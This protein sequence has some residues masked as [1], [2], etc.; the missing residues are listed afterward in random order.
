MLRVLIALLLGTAAEAQPVTATLEPSQYVEVRAA[1]SGRLSQLTGEEGARVATGDVLAAIDASVQAARVRLAEAAA[2]ATGST[3][4]GE[5]ALAMAETARDRIVEARERGVAQDWEVE[6]SEQT[7]ALAEADLQMVR[8]ELELNLGQL[9]MER[10]MLEEFRVRAPFDGTVLQVFRENGEIVDTQSV[11][12]Q[13]GNLA[14]LKAT[15]FVPVD[16]L[17]GLAPG[18]S[19]EGVLD[20]GGDRVDALVTSIDPRMDPASR[21]VRVTLEIPN[22]EGRYLVGSALQL[23]LP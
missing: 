19:I 18:S 11:L 9:A 20:I 23:E 12:L 8:D 1:V 16:R 5:R 15:A 22:P 4:R 13:V 14:T 17:A 21:T 7:V 3:L 6:R 10:A 2:S